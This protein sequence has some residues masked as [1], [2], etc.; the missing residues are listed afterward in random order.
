MELIKHLVERTTGKVPSGAK[1][2]SKWPTVRKHHLERNP[3]CAV[4]GG[5][6]K[7][8][9]HH[10]IPFHID[11]SKELDASNLITLCEG[12][13]FVNCHLMFGHLGSYRSLNPNVVGDASIWHD[14]L[15]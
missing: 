12:K 13:K 15:Q 3:T 10:I 1:R 5:I 7:I 8:E 6:E 14:K 4:C 2:S 11:E 9:V